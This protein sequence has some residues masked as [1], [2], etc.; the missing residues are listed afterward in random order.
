MI[1]AVVY[2]GTDSVAIF[3]GRLIRVL[4]RMSDNWLWASETVSSDSELR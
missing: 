4:G 2:F 1:C 3:P